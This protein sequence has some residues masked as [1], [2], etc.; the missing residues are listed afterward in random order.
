MNPRNFAHSLTHSGNHQFYRK[1]NNNSNLK[2]SSTKNGLESPFNRNDS[3]NKAAVNM[4]NVMNMMVES[5]AIKKQTNTKAQ[6]NN[7]LPVLQS[8]HDGIAKMMNDVV[9]NGQITAWS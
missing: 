7:V 6:V 1:L 4:Q 5:K 8:M 9:A 3:H 2:I